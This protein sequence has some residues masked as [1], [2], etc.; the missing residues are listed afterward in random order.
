M[1]I[2]TQGMYILHV[3]FDPTDENRGSQTLYIPGINGVLFT[4]IVN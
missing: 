2:Y 4:F 1:L 3:P